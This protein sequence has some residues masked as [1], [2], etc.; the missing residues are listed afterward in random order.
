MLTLTIQAH[1]HN[2]EEPITFFEWD[3]QN[4]PYC[5]NLTAILYDDKPPKERQWG[6]S[7]EFTLNLLMQHHSLSM[8]FLRLFL[9]LLYSK[10]SVRGNNR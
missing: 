8:I 5:K 7:G 6:Y 10:E 2:S 3:D 9:H 4:V 1:V